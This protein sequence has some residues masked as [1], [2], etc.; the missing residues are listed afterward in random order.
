LNRSYDAVLDVRGW[1][2]WKKFTKKMRNARSKAIRRR[3]DHYLGLWQDAAYDKKRRLQNRALATAH[4]T[5]GLYI[6][7]WNSW[8][9]A[10][11]IKR[12]AG[13]MQVQAVAHHLRTQKRAGDDAWIQ[14]TRAR[15]HYKAQALNA[16][17]WNDQRTKLTL[18]TRW[19]RNASQKQAL[20]RMVCVQSL[21]LSALY[22]LER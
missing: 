11:A 20:Q 17:A 1:S 4:A 5:R 15:R 7:V 3:L 2:I 16:V 13:L 12:K 19:F 14:N 22:H 9:L 10:L 8:G 21:R 6:A 18:F